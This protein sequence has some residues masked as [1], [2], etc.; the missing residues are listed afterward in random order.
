MPYYPT[1]DDWQTIDAADA[2]MDGERLADAAAFAEEEETAWPRDLSKGLAAGTNTLEPPPW[3]KVL[4]PTKDRGSPN[5]LI[6]RGGHIVAEWGDTR[7]TDM[8]FSIAKSYLSM[9]TGVAVA[10][11][12]IRDVDDPVRE[13]A[14][15][16]GFDSEQNRGIT[17]RHLLQQ[18]SEWEGTLWDKP[19]LVDRNRQVGPGKDN[20]RKGTH[21]D[22]QPPG[23]FWEYNDVRV[24]RLSLCLLQVFRRPLPEVLAETIMGP[25][26]ASDTWEWHAYGNARFAIDGKDMPSVPG[27]AHW[28]GGIFI[29]SRDHARVGLMMARGGRWNDQQVL[30]G[31]W[32]DAS[33]TPCAINPE[34]GYLWWLNPGGIHYDQAPD[35]SYFAIGAGQSTI[36]VDPGLDLVMVSR[37][38][39]E[40]KVN[41]L[42]GRVMGSLVA[43]ARGVEALV[44]EN[45][46]R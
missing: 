2:G 31:A 30:P 8:T 45:A 10:Q 41:A 21:R 33:R 3:N 23:S 5:G 13:Y 42:I 7:R 6:L 17:W 32:I 29:S 34:Y 27:G 24:N 15:D 25:I 1:R 44:G 39:D 14:L 22:L 35:S 37:W 46:G 38:N 19:D 4:G 12:L 11:G 43:P 40:A 16:D 20:S 18:T 36:W 26:G 9:L 28:G